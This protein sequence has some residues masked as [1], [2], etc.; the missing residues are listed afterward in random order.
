MTDHYDSMIAS[1]HESMAEAQKMADAG[2]IFSMAQVD[3]IRGGIVDLER[4]AAIWR[5]KTPAQRAA[6]A[7]ARE[8]KWEAFEA[9]CAAKENEPDDEEE[10]DCEA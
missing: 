3:A 1:L 8:A 10:E 6:D 4:E 5:A 9:A 2:D 7:A